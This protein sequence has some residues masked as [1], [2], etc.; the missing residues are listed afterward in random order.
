MRVTS[1]ENKP[2]E[3][4]LIGLEAKTACIGA[5]YTHLLPREDKMLP[6]FQGIMYV[7]HKIDV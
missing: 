2:T 3:L 4:R 5:I 7:M 1:Y 6:L